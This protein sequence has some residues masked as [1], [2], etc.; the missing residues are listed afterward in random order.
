M[1]K[2]TAAFLLG[3]VLLWLM[4]PSLYYVVT[5]DYNVISGQCTI[6]IDTSGRA[7][8]AMINMRE[9]DDVFYFSDMSYY[10][11]VTVTKDHV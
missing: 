2:I 1:I 6:Q 5:E 9:K 8:Q 7:A 3:I 10:C 11:D 4:M